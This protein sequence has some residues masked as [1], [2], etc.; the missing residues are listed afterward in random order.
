MDNNRA[1]SKVDI[2]TYALGVLGGA[3]KLVPT[4]RI[5]ELCHRLSPAQFS[6]VLPDY[7]DRGWPDKY[8]TKTALEDAKKK[9][10]GALV[11]GSYQRDQSKDGWRLTAAGAEWFLENERLIS[12]KLR[13]GPQRQAGKAEQ[14]ILKQLRDHS[15]FI[16]FGAEG[17]VDVD[18]RYVFLDLL[19]CSP[20]AKTEVIRTK[21]DR[22][23]AVAEMAGDSEVK[24]FLSACLEIF[25]PG[26]EFTTKGGTDET[27]SGT[28]G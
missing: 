21:L 20:D 10:Y 5:A 27:E 9:A 7:R 16:K 28:D 15:L 18:D 8:V 19:N 23:A 17:A 6:W 2:V 11:S 24:S 14:R 3:E 22:L 26:G 12:S 4:E 1:P 13:S 25:L